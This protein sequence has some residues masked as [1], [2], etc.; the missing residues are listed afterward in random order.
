MTG[1]RQGRSR[2]LLENYYAISAKG[3]VFDVDLIGPPFK[4]LTEI[5]IFAGVVHI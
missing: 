3:S 2:G 5:H 1:G 4:S